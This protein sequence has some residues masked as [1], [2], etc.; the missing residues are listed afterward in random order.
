MQELGAPA[1]HDSAV[2]EAESTLGCGT[3][4]W[5]HA[6]VRKGARVG[7]QCVIGKGV[8]IDT[9]VVVGDR[10]KLQNNVSLY[11]GAV[12][13]DGVFIGPHVVLTNDHL[14]R[15]INPDGTLKSADDWDV[16]RILVRSGASIG[17]GSVI[18]PDVEIGRWALVGAGSL[19]TSDLPDHGLAFGSPARLRGYICRCGTARASQ[20]ELL[21]CECLPPDD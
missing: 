6:H 14:P 18:L 13:E 10:V 9:D 16:G 3:R 15:A 17:A 12:I 21:R 1:I 5:H 2:V 8:Y 4:V 7:A 11:R 20:R 19:V